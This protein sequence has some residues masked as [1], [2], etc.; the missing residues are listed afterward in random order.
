[1]PEAHHT[2][3]K[4]YLVGFADKEGAVVVDR[5]RPPEEQLRAQIR[6]PIKRISTRPDQYA[7]RRSTGLDY[8]PERAFGLMEN[9]IPRLRKA[10]RTGPLSNE[11]LRDW[12]RLAGAQHYRGRNRAVM[13]GPFREMM[14][15][16]RAEAEAQGRDGDEAE[17]VFV[18]TRIYD[19]DIAHDPENLALLAG[20][21]VMQTALDWFNDM[22]KCVLTSAAGDFITSDEPV[23]LFDPV[24]VKNGDRQALKRIPQSQDC[25][26][27]YPLDRRF[28]LLMS[29]RR[30]V[31]EAYADDSVVETINART[32]WFSRDEVYVAPCDAR[33]QDA[34]LRAFVNKPA[35]LASLAARYAMPPDA[36]ADAQTPWMESKA[37]ADRAR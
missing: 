20:P 34:A 9:R 26:V 7:L 35:M 12:T 14:D 11:D 33:G 30:I 21:N 10:L 24:A 13:A 28:C 29:Y 16:A 3:P 22:Y 1:M 17:R 31:S 32:A 8:G 4:A 5:H 2:L 19:G 27:T 18:Q 6:T 37:A 25:E 36:E 23:V 15:A